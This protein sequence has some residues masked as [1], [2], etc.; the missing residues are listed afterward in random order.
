[1]TNRTEL[2]RQIAELQ[3][4]LAALRGDKP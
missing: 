2:E 3:A 1:M 4:Q